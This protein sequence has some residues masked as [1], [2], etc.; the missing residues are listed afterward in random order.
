[1]I[2]KYEQIFEDK[3]PKEKKPKPKA[4]KA[5][6][7]DIKDK[8]YAEDPELEDYDKFIDKWADIDTRPVP[9]INNKKKG[10]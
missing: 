8:I 5:G 2:K 3:T 4:K 6:P 7:V 9:K 1:M 10:L